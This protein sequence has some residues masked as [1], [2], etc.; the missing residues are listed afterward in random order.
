MDEGRVSLYRVLD[1][2]APL[3]LAARGPATPCGLWTSVD[4]NYP[5]ALLA[6]DLVTTARL[7]PLVEVVLEAG[8]GECRRLEELVNG[9][10]DPVGVLT[11]GLTLAGG[12]PRPVRVWHPSNGELHR[13]DDRRRY[14]VVG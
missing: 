6:R 11:P 10:S 1:A 2:P 7:V 14:D 3:A 8:E 9:R 12:A 5:L 4:E 13:G